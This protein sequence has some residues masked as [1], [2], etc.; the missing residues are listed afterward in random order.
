LPTGITTAPRDDSD[1]DARD[2]AP[3]S[4]LQ[5]GDPDA[6]SHTDTRVS[7][8]VTPAADTTPASGSTIGATVLALSSGA[9]HFTAPVCPASAYSCA[10]DTKNAL[11]SAPSDGDAVTP[12]P[13]CVVHLP[14]PLD[15]KATATPASVP[16]IT[17]PSLDTTGDD[18]TPRVPLATHC[19]VPFRK[20]D[21]TPA[22]VPTTNP[23]PPA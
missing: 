4:A 10:E 5:R 1:V 21:A 2:D 22:L 3:R 9:L 15:D 17:L 23:A 12:L 13:S 16:T 7:L 14:A 6:P 11:L 8:P 18:D 20:Y 19:S